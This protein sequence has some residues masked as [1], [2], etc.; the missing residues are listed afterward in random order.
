MVRCFLFLFGLLCKRQ[1][2]LCD[3]NISKQFALADAQGVHV[4]EKN[5][6]RPTI[7]PRSKFIPPFVQYNTSAGKQ[8]KRTPSSSPPKPQGPHP[9]AASCPRAHRATLCHCLRRPLRPPPRSSASA[10]P[11][12]EQHIGLCGRPPV[13]PPRRPRGSTRN[14]PQ[15]WLSRRASAGGRAPRLAHRAAC[16]RAGGAPGLLR[17]CSGASQRRPHR[18]SAP[19]ERLFLDMA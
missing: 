4:S 9:H 2:A 16:C 8:K 14:R 5:L 12:P 18:P 1:H 15:P 19:A 13:P 7:F 3:S 10:P 6:Q 11:P 17:P